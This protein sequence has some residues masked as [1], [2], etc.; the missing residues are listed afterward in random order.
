MD[1]PITGTTVGDMYGGA[2]SPA[3]R[4]IPAGSE[5]IFTP[6]DPTNVAAPTVTGTSR[7]GGTMSAQ[8]GAWTGTPQIGYGYQWQRCQ[9]DGD[10]CANIP[11]ATGADYRVT[12]A[13]GGSE[14]RVVVTG[15]NWISSVSQARSKFT[16]DTVPTV[17][18]AAGASRKAKPP[19]LTLLEGQD[20]PAALRGLAQAQ[21][22]RH[23]P[24]RLPRDL[25]AQPLGQGAGSRSSA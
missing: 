19:R 17:P 2:R 13:D 14:L 3:G 20:E 16:P 15:G 4:Q 25:E 21:A 22:P 23:A 18:T 10:N 12:S 5:R 11:G 8:Q 24:R 6:N 7:V 1:V 9:S